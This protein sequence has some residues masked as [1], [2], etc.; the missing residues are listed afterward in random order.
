MVGNWSGQA[1]Q[2]ADLLYHLASRRIARMTANV[3]RRLGQDR[4]PIEQHA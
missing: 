1:R 2:I 3:P 4:S